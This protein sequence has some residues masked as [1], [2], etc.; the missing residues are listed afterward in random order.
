MVSDRMLNSEN[1]FH[2]DIGYPILTSKHAWISI[3]LSFA[4]VQEHKTTG[5]ANIHPE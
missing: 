4:C 2:F 3:I 1:H 5:I